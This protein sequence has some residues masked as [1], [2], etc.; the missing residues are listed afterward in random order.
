MRAAA[1]LLATLVAVGCG[2]DRG[3]TEAAASPMGTWNL[4]TIGGARLPYLAYEDPYDGR[5]E[6]L[7]QTVTIHENTFTIRATFRQTYNGKVVTAA[8]SVVGWAS[9]TGSSALLT[10]TEAG[11]VVT[12]KVVGAQLTIDDGVP[13]VYNRR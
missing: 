7:D 13:F 6:L 1:V 12:G 5:I 10:S 8:D 11:I 4:V 2:S 9:I 3:I